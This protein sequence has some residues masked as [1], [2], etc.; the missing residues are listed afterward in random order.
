MTTHSSSQPIARHA[1]SFV[2]LTSVFVGVALGAG[3]LSTLAYAGG[4]SGRTPPSTAPTLYSWGHNSAGQ[5]GSGTTA[6]N[7]TPGAVTLPGGATAVQV[8]AGSDFSLAVGS[9][10]NLYAWGDN[11]DGQLGDGTTS[12]SSTPVEVS[13][14]AAA[15]PATAVAAGDAFAMAIGADGNVYSWGDN[16]HG[17][18]GNGTTMA[19]S[20]PV[21]VSL[22]SGDAASSITAGASFALATL[23]TPG[24][25]SCLPRRCATSGARTSGLAGRA[26]SWHGGDAWPG[27]DAALPPRVD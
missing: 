27:P 16:T 8:G 6:D 5:L 12:S 19:S 2:R 18:L 11:A 23:A 4:V 24:T 10:G 14:P 1:R 20:T 13:L 22:P 7:A 15:E 25:Y 3:T 9:D 17:Q 21:K 26:P